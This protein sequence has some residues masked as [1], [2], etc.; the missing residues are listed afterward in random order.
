MTEEIT[1]TKNISRY[2]KICHKCHKEIY[3]NALEP[4]LWAF[5]NWHYECVKLP[6]KLF[7]EGKK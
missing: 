2:I 5:A 6:F 3:P 7:Q 1:R 4:V